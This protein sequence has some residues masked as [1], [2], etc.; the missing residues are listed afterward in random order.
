MSSA[1]RAAELRVRDLAPTDHEWA[2]GL[3]ASHQAGTHQVARLGELLDPL[4]MDGLVAEAD[5]EAVGL[6]TVHETPE[7]GLEVVLLVAD[8]AGIGAGSALLE[9]ARQVAAA[10]GHHRLWLVTTNDNLQAIHFYL[11]RG[12]H[13]AGVHLDAVARDR[14]LK[15]QISERNADNGLPIRDLV[16]F[17]LRDEGVK[18]PLTRREFPLTQDLDKL[19]P[20]AFVS[21]TMPLFEGG[22]RFLA[23]LAESRPFE[24]D[25]GVIAAAFEAARGA[26]EDE[27]V[28]LV[29]AHPP[30]GADPETVSPMSYVEQ[31]YA[32]ESAGAGVEGEEGE[33]DAEEEVEESLFSDAE[34]AEEAAALRAREVARAYEELQMLNELY[35][36]RFGFRYVVF[37]AGRPKT[38]IVPLLERALQGDRD[39]E[40]RRAVDD[41]IYIAGDRLRRLR[42][43]GAEE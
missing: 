40:L 24:T 3:I 23:R 31:G 7:K 32:E 25:E 35:E 5:G 12:M 22:E 11:R 37:V 13:V 42:G 1:T 2:R 28:E 26:S 20:E 38:E 19:P 10:S 30:I 33:E 29:Q 16:E 36:Q 4:T 43:L 41:A 9:T 27:Q 21:E 34:L 39:A 8:P 18:A 14:A 17:E 15:P 6:A